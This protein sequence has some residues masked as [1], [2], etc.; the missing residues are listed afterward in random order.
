MLSLI[1]GEF[2]RKKDYPHYNE[3]KSENQLESIKQ[4]WAILYTFE[5]G[6]N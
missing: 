6:I 1:L 2:P 3:N 4:S 5:R